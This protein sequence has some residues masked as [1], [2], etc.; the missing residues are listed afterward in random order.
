MTI[1]ESFALEVP[2][3]GANHSGFKDLV[4]DGETGFLLDF[5]DKEIL[6]RLT[7]IDN[8]TI[9]DLKEN[10][11]AYYNNNLSP[12]IHLREIISVYKNVLNK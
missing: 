11:K 10:V 7:E 6:K 1:I 8:I 9:D 4:K 12:E 5:S 3:I 2:V